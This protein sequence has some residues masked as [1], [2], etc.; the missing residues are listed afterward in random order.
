MSKY[1]IS[2]Q[3]GEDCNPEFGPDKEMMDGLECDGFFMVGFKNGQPCFESMMG[4][5]VNVLSK[6]IKTRNEG[7]QYIREACAIAEGEIR[8][9]EIS[10]EIEKENG[11]AVTI[12]GTMPGWSAD[13]IRRI[14]GK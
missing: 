13:M 9:L 12:T 8:A 1:V 14:F 6:W 7:A 3:A 2:V 5:T 10:N 11:N 4:T